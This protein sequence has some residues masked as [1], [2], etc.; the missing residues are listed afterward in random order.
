MTRKRPI[1]VTVTSFLILVNV[2]IWL[3]LGI[4]IITDT[5]IAIPDQPLIKGTMAVLSLIAAGVLLALFFLIR[6]G[7]RT[8][9]FLTLAV[10]IITALLVFFDDVGV[11]DLVVLSLNLTP[12]VL[13]IKDR[14]WY[15]KARPRIERAV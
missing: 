14:A 2:L 1:S 6:H 10:F 8:A 7:N 3:I 9:Y 4:L 15:R 11:S 13:L 5:H 12:I